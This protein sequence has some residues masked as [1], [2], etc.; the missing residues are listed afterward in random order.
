MGDDFQSV[1]RHKVKK[2]SEIP[3]ADK[4]ERV[5]FESGFV[6]VAGKDTVRET[7]EYYVIPADSVLPGQLAYDLALQGSTDEPMRLRAKRIRGVTC[8]C[9]ILPYRLL[10]TNTLTVI[11]PNVG[12]M[13]GIRK[14]RSPPVE[15]RKPSDSGPEADTRGQEIDRTNEYAKYTMK[16]DIHNIK[17]HTNAFEEGENVVITEKIHGCWFQVATVAGEGFFVTSKGLAARGVSFK[18]EADNLWTRTAADPSITSI[19]V[20][21]ME[22]AA[23]LGFRFC[24]ILGEIYGKGVQDLHYGAKEPRFCIFDILVGHNADEY[25]YLRPSAVKT[26]CDSAGAPYVPVIYRG[27]YQPELIPLLTRGNTTIVNV[28][29]IREGIVVRPDDGSKNARLP[30][31]RKI[32]KSINPEYLARGKNAD[33]EEPSESQ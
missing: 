26:L 10:K 4:I 29:Q 27:P 28:K 15:D 17:Y 12:E 22:I 19:L 7:D 18:N 2:V 8:D 11:K 24:S 32:L 21:V 5:E 31:G 9:V 23:A 20:V 30:G 16:F 33:G 14:F 25:I 3:G 6:T 1:I 13:M